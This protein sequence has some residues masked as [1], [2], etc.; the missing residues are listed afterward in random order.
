MLT[1]MIA[2]LLTEATSLMSIDWEAWCGS[3]TYAV[4][5]LLLSD[6]ADFYSTWQ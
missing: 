6:G 1:E 3:C 2:I 5:R 4:S